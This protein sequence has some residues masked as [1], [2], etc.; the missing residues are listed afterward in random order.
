MSKD[1]LNRLLPEYMQKT[2]TKELDDGDVI[3]FALF[4]LAE[5]KRRDDRERARDI[6]LEGGGH[7]FRLPDGTTGEWTLSQLGTLFSAWRAPATQCEHCDAWLI[8]KYEEDEK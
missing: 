8:V 3:E 1:E 7:F 6:C 5:K 4:V 2:G